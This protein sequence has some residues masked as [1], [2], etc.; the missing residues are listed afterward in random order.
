M[1]WAIKRLSPTAHLTVLATFLLTY[2]KQTLVA[3][4]KRNVLSIVVQDRH[5]YFTL[6]Y[7][8]NL[9]QSELAKKGTIC[10]HRCIRLLPSFRCHILPSLQS[11]MSTRVIIQRN[12]PF[13]CGC[14]TGNLLCI[15]KVT[16]AK[17]AVSK[18]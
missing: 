1:E 14:V 15:Q 16:R 3:A 8:Q 6:D 2:C 10:V 18:Q 12:R 11:K 5:R 7:F 13:V 4:I 9:H 17:S